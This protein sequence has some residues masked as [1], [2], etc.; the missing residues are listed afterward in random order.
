M[1]G[2]SGTAM[3][4]NAALRMSLQIAHCAVPASA[5][6]IQDN[7]LAGLHAVQIGSSGSS[8][9]SRTNPRQVIRSHHENKAI[10]MMKIKGVR[11]LD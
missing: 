4:G 9:Q 8:L 2:V 11:A 7:F 5:S 10:T 6:A 3:H 1:H